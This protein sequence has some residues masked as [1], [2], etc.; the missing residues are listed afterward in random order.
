MV[1][2]VT[3]VKFLLLFVTRLFDIFARIR[4]IIEFDMLF[5]VQQWI[6]GMRTIIVILNHRTVFR[7]VLGSRTALTSESR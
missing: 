6:T 7:S 1:R 2:R 4:I 5:N 3:S